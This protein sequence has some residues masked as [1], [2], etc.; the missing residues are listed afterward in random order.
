MRRAEHGWQQPDG[1]CSNQC[2]RRKWV[3]QARD[4]FSTWCLFC[5]WSASHCDCLTATNDGPAQRSRNSHQHLSNPHILHYPWTSTIHLWRSRK[6]PN[7]PTSQY[8]NNLGHQ[9]KPHYHDNFESCGNLGR[10]WGHCTTV[11]T[12]WRT[13]LEGSDSLCQ[14][15]LQG[16][17]CLLQPVPPV[18]LWKRTGQMAALAMAS[19]SGWVWADVYNGAGILKWSR[20]VFCVYIHLQLGL[21]ISYQLRC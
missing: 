17:W 15:N 9:Q 7:Y 10:D 16:Q 14:R 2:H 1:M 21:F 3:S 8:T 19:C 20:I 13:W 12:V 18:S 4:C 11:W 5:T 6:L